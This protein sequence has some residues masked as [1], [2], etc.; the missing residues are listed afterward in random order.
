MPLRDWNGESVTPKPKDSN[1]GSRRELMMVQLK[2]G[3]A[4]WLLGEEGDVAHESQMQIVMISTGIAYA[5]V[6]LISPIVS[7]LAGTF[8][9]SHA[10]VGDLVTAFAAPSIVLVPLAG[11]LADRIGRRTVLV[12]GLVLFG[13]G[14][15]AI[16]FTSS[17]QVVIALRVL[18]GVGYAAINPVGVAL[19]GDLYSGGREATAQGLRVVG[20]QV[21]NLG[22][23]LLAGVLVLVAWQY[24]FLFYG[25]SFFVA[26]W[27]WRSLPTVVPAEQTTVRDYAANL[28]TSLRDPAMALVLASFLLR[29]SLV[30]AF[31]TYISVLLQE[32]TGGTAVASGSVVTLYGLVALVGS[33][34]GGRLTTVF[35]PFEV[36][37]AGFLVG[38]VG[39]GLLGSDRSFP[40]LIVGV[41][42]FSAGYSVVGPIQKSLVTQFSPPSI[43]A[44]A[45][46]SAVVVQSIGQTVGPLAMGVSLQ[47]VSVARA[48]LVFGVGGSLL[49]ALSITAAARLLDSERDLD[50]TPG[51]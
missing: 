29:F 2:D 27:A 46:S 35:D 25:I 8:Q 24:P 12:G 23:P 18:Q 14:G 42:V 47:A 1:T 38:G 15:T 21:I 49:G 37:V 36:L 16:A 9:V 5:G 34:Q 30:F 51:D 20:I 50:A 44:G 31:F 6:F 19:L 7:T 17:F 33:S 10:R 22:A 39:F 41:L 32:S 45:V 26:A 3:L 40:V 4:T 48:F 28:V 13:L 11:M 43:R